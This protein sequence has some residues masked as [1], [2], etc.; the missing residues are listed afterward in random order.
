MFRCIFKEGETIMAPKNQLPDVMHGKKSLY[1]PHR[2]M[3]RL[4]HRIDRM[5]EDFFSTPFS[6]E[7]FFLEPILNEGYT[8]LCDCDETDTHYLLN[9][10]LP[11][12][13]KADVKIDFKDNQLSVSGERKGESKSG[14]GRER[15]YG[16]FYRSFTLPSNINADKIEA[17]FENGVLQ[18]SIPKTEISSGKQIPI[19]E[20]K[21]L[22]S[23]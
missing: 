23:K 17:N 22:E 4:Q 12:V 10:D 5:F 19:K 13:K 18:I 15:F 14:Q 21:L 1:N 11:G 20:G 16:S 2:E 9:F 3:H 8:P 7:R 6:S